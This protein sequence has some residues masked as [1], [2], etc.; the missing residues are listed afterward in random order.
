MVGSVEGGLVSVFDCGDGD[1]NGDG[2]GGCG[3]T[4]SSMPL[5]TSKATSGSLY[6]AYPSQCGNPVER[7]YI[8]RDMSKPVEDLPASDW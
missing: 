3:C 8:E 4:W 7:K 2:E 5:L 6:M 1:G